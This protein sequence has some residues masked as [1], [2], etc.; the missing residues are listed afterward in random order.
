MMNNAQTGSHGEDTALAYLRS[1]GYRFNARN[2]RLGRDEIDLVLYD[3]EDQVMV[4]AEV[5]ARSSYDPDYAPELNIT[6]DKKRKMYRAA[7]RWIHRR[8]YDGGWR[9]DVLLVIGDRVVDH[10]CDVSCDSA[11]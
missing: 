2:V 1:I 11:S 8:A 6:H 10:W 7:E 9:L 5:K 4:F 3:P